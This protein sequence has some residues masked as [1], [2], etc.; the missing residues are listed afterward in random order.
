[1]YGIKVIFGTVAIAS[2]IAAL[3]L[4]WFDTEF[5]FGVTAA[6]VYASL[7][8]LLAVTMTKECCSIEIE[9]Y[10]QEV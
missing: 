5:V 8:V 4:I 2:V 1:M 7:F 10:E 3:A 9:D 6:K